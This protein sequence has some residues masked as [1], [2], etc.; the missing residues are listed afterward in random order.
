[1]PLSHLFLVLYLRYD[2]I[3]VL[4]IFGEEPMYTW[5]N[6]LLSLICL[7]SVNLWMIHISFDRLTNCLC[8]L[9]FSH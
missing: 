9:I 7:E 8:H 2:C 1:M 6:L 5:L 3:D 4:T